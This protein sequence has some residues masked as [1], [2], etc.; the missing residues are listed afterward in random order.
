MKKTK[1]LVAVLLAVLLLASTLA[2]PASAKGFSDIPKGY[3]YTDAVNYVS[4]NNIMVGT[5][6]TMFE[7][8][9]AITRAMMISL[10]Y[11]KAG[12]PS[13]SGKNPFT[14]VPAGAYYEKAVIWAVQKGITHGTSATTFSP[15]LPMVREEAMCFLYNYSKKTTTAVNKTASITGYYD[16]SDVSSFARN[17]MSWAVGN[18]ILIITQTNKLTPKYTMSRIQAAYALT[19]FGTNVERCIRGSDILSFINEGISTASNPNQHFS[20]SFYLK[21][22]HKTKF[23]T[24]F[25]LK[26]GSGAQYLSAVSQVSN[27]LIKPAEGR[28]FGMSVVTALDKYGKINFNGIVDN[29]G[30]T[31]SSVPCTPSSVAESTIT[32]YHVSQ[33]LSDIG[34]GNIPEWPTNIGSVLNGM[35]TATGPS[36]FV[37]YAGHAPDT[38]HYDEGFAHAVLVNKCE[39][40]G[41]NYILRIY[42]STIAGFSTWTITWNGTRYNLPKLNYT[43]YPSIAYG[44]EYAYSITDFSKFDFLDIDGYQNSRAAADDAHSRSNTLQTMAENTDEEATPWDNYPEDFSTVYFRLQNGVTITNDSGKTLTWKDG[45]LSGDMEVY[46]WNFIVGTSPV[47]AYADVPLSKTFTMETPEGMQQAFSVADKFRYQCI[48]NFSGTAELCGEGTMNLIGNLDDFTATCFFPGDGLT[49]T[50]SGEGTQSVILDFAG[51]E[52][53]ANGMAGNYTLQVTD[54]AGEILETEAFSPAVDD[55]EM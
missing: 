30:S 53:L 35:C 46:G 23:Y 43:D 48:E 11:R 10:L 15:D 22:A 38:P 3:L 28:C 42:D 33:A 45:E 54:E 39:K 29:A 1:R 44:I 8:G 6:D 17:A 36:L 40:S 25:S 55:S 9:I 16:Y 18:G 41:N 50:I 14:D 47:L 37:F 20:S 32:Y 13:V 34:A 52:V 27:A 5:S 24:K 31:M 2:V 26:Y 12:K 7:P 51:D 4:D 49:R 21:P 19:A